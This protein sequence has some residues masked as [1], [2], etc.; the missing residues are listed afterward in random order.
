MARTTG[1]TA[2]AA[3][4]MAC[5]WDG[6]LLGCKLRTGRGA[7]TMVQPNTCVEGSPRSLDTSRLRSV[8]SNLT[9]VS[10]VVRQR[11]EL[12]VTDYGVAVGCCV[13]DS[14]T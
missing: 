1:P 9:L 7:S 8:S 14:A 13:I 6:Q 3:P 4:G 11:G 10:P 2:A 12:A 5:Q